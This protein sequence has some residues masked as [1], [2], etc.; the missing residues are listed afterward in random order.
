M[1]CSKP[2]GKFKHENANVVISTTC[3]EMAKPK[4]NNRSLFVIIIIFL[5]LWITHRCLSHVGPKTE[6][7]SI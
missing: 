7:K 2:P 3:V 6:S 4:Q 1:L 5:L